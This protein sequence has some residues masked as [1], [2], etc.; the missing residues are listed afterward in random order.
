MTAG[1]FNNGRCLLIRTKAGID[2]AECAI[3][4]REYAS[5]FVTAHTCKHQIAKGDESDALKT[6]LPNI[7]KLAV[8]YSRWYVTQVLTGKATPATQDLIDARVDICETNAC[9]LYA[10]SKCHDCGC[11]VTRL[12]AHEGRNKAAWNEKDCDRGYWKNIEI[13][14]IPHDNKIQEV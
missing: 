11:L 14:E 9:G 8:G 3:C 7:I 10:R 1:L 13:E 6:R 2:A 12:K 5:I 4:G